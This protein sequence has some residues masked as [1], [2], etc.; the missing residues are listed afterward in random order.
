[1]TRRPRR[2][3]R[4]ITAAERAWAEGRPFETEADEALLTYFTPADRLRYIWRVVHGE[5]YEDH[6]ARNPEKWKP[7]QVLERLAIVGFLTVADVE[8]LQAG[9]PIT[10]TD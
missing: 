10:L 3:N 2:P 9:E 6:L 4:S 1:M 5:D 7:G 8:R